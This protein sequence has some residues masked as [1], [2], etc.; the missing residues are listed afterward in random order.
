VVLSVLRTNRKNVLCFFKVD[1]G[2]LLRRYLRIFHLFQIKFEKRS[3]PNKYLH[4]CS[5]RIHSNSTHCFET[6]TIRKLYLV[7]YFYLCWG[8][9]WKISH[10]INLLDNTYLNRSLTVWRFSWSYNGVIDANLKRSWRINAHVY[11]FF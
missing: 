11:V 10:H 2:N 8:G 6:I 1:R 9:G 4:F 5:H 3:E 7:F